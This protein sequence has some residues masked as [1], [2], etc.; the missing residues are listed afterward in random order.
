MTPS[1]ICSLGANFPSRPSTRA[2]TNV[3][4]VA[5]ATLPRTNSRRV[6]LADV[7]M[8]HL[9]EKLN[10]CGHPRCR[11]TARKEETDGGWRLRRVPAAPW[12]HPRPGTAAGR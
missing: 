10:A 4:T 7:L 12:R 11:P 6:V 5:A 3:A 8:K 2:G 9:L 1:V